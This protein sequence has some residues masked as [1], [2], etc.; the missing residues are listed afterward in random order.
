MPRGIY[1]ED[2][3]H[4]MVDYGNYRTVIPRYVYE[5]NHYEPLYDQLPT[6][7]EFEARDA[8]GS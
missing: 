1:K 6:Q 4:V 7:E 5:T 8:Q 2:D 3:Q